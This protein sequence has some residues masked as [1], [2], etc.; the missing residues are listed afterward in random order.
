MATCVTRVL[1]C[2]IIPFLDEQLTN[3]GLSASGKSDGSWMSITSRAKKQKYFNASGTN[4]T[5]HD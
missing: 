3:E 4:V 2:A 5:I 1:A